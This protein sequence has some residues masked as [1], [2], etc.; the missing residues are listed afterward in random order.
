LFE[1]RIFSNF[2]QSVTPQRLFGWLRSSSLT[3]YRVVLWSVLAAG[4]AFAAL[5]LGLRYWMLPNIDQYREQLA[6][7][8]SEAANQRVTIGR[9]SGDWDGIRPHLVLADV[10]VHDPGGRPV[11]TLSRVENVLSWLSLATLEPRFHSLEIREPA[12]AVRRDVHGVI[13]IAG[14]ELKEEHGGGGFADWLLRQREIIVRDATVTWH[15]E[16]RGA[17]P[18]RLERVDLLMHN[19][20]ERHRFG[21][22]GTPP[23]QLAGRLDIRGELRGRTVAELA[24]WNGRLFAELDYADIAAWQAWI[25][26]PIDVRQGAGALRMWLTFSGSALSDIVADVRLADVRSHLARDLPELDLTELSGRVAWKTS[27]AGMEFS[28]TKLGLTAQNGLTLH[29]VDFLLRLEAARGR[30]PARGEMRANALDLEPL[31][32]L[33]DRLP[34]DAALRRHLI[35]LSPKGSLFDL[36]ARWSGEW[37][38]AQQFS[39]RGRFHNLAANRFGS[40]PGFSGLTGN[41]DGNERAGTLHVSSNDLKLEMPAVL[42]EPLALDTLV[43]QV[44]WSRSVQDTELRLNNVSFAN[45]DLAGTLFGS[46]RAVPGRRGVIDLTGSLS[47]ADA[48]RAGRYVP[49]VVGKTTRDWL[50]SSILSGQSDDVA[51]RLKGDLDQFP[52][53][54]GRGGVFQVT[55]KITG[56]ALDYAEG[57]PKME[58]IAGDLVFRGRRMDIHARRGS[59]LGVQIGNVRAEIPDLM[60]DKELLRISGEA[61]GPT[62]DFLAFIENSPVLGMIDRF[63]EGM[64][65]EGGGRLALKLEIPL[66][67]LAASTVA[68]TY[69]F[70]NNRIMAD[71]DLPSLEQVSGHL[72]FTESAVQVPGA[73]AVF[74]G[75]PVTVTG[76][77]RGDGTVGIGLQGRVDIDNVRRSAG[78]PWWAENLRGS[79]DWKGLLTLRGRLADLEIESSL[80]GMASNLPAPFIKAAAETVPLR[81]SRTFTGQQQERISFSY[82]DVVSGKLVRRTE[83]RRSVVTQ[84][85]VRFGGAAAEPEYEG[86]W[87]GG[88]MPR[89]DLD[90]WLV[91]ARRSKGEL[92]PAI[93]GIDVRIDEL[94]LLGRP[95]HDVA[96]NGAAQQGGTWHT[97]LTAREFEGTA[98]WRAQGRGKLTARMKRLVVPAGQPA[99]AGAPPPARQ[100]LPGLDIVADQ[101]QFKDKALGRLELLATPEDRDWRIDK[102]RV[103]NPDSTLAVVG[104]V[105]DMVAQPRT[106]VTLQLDTGDIGKLLTRLGYP[107]GVRRGTAKLEGSLAWAGAPQDFE[108]SALSG[109]LVLEAAKGQFVKLEPGIGKLLGILSLQSLP[110]R[111]TLDFRDIFSEGFAFDQIVG[112]VRINEGIASTDSFRINGPSARVAM[113]GEVDLARE[114]QKLRVRITPS[115]STRIAAVQMASG[116]QYR[117]NLNEAARLIE[118]AAGQGA[119]LVALPEYFGIM[120][121]RGCRQGAAAREE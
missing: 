48:R 115:I 103:T 19:R 94:A 91:F 95:F 9:I 13:S 20:G 55:A 8:V 25:S 14:T 71:P 111:I 4:L 118:M 37:R 59:I 96:L 81:F 80:Q 69:R 6:Q 88:R 89:L 46:Y 105:Q 74:L 67:A 77:T 92:L 53:P 7:A 113:T 34:L 51:L 32:L 93:H 84:G 72:Q 79:T 61:E 42:R 73:S 33:A 110:R 54:D 58:N 117:G 5:I 39:V 27:A 15:D 45:P 28:A 29:P 87:V 63:T 104:I 49:L 60:A 75:G 22:H 52:F 50:E 64:R 119:R 121:M 44:A 70:I 21:L 78:N 36:A 114:T 112:T 31:V 11:L 12:L 76:S 18:L 83:G 66:G 56:G 1:Y 43:A 106:R 62:G 102:L 57:W 2:R 47:R 30:L 101:F 120:G 38:Q 41:I 109:S 108:Y 82:G 26:Y 3:I 100:D 65:A 16:L 85:N 98:D 107:E 35:E 86:I 68:G 116:P 10:T 17:A 24:A 90:R 97:T 99:A 40:L 23:P